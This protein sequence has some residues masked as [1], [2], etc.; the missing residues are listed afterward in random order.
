METQAFKTHSSEV[1]E[2]FL[3]LLYVTI[4][5]SGLASVSHSKKDGGGGG[6]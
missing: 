2:S 1:A 6:D 4:E 3:P 5:F